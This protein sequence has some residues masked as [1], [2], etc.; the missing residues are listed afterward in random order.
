MGGFH[1]EKRRILKTEDSL[2]DDAVR[3]EPLSRQLLNRLTPYGS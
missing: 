3:G 2:A 1:A